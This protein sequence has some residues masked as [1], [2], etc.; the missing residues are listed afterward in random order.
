MTFLNWYVLKYSYIIL[1]GI[2]FENVDILQIQIPHMQM[3]EM[4]GIWNRLEGLNKSYLTLFG[5][6]LCKKREILRYVHTTQA[7]VVSR[8]EYAERC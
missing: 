2:L 1:A 7:G 8:K 4:C 3:Q 6:N 5:V